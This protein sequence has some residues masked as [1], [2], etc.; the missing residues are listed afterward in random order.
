MTVPYDDMLYLPHPEP[1]THPR[2]PIETRAAQFAPFSALTGFD[3]AVN[4]M[5][6][7][8]EFMPEVTEEEK[9][10]IDA[11]LQ[12]LQQSSDETETVLTYY[13]PDPRKEGGALLTAVGSIRRINVVRSTITLADGTTVPFSRIV[14]LEILTSQ[15]D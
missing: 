6:R 12:Q 9:E 1:K 13:R 2:M 10:R 8:T 11:A 3:D 7:Y 14:R 4:E 5:A 15:I